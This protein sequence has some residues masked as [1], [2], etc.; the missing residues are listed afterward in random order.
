MAL[1]EA[2]PSPACH[3]LKLLIRTAAQVDAPVE[4]MALPAAWASK[5]VACG[6]TL[7][8]HHRVPTTAI[9]LLAAASERMRVIEASGP[10]AASGVVKPW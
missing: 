8:G 5:T 3:L 2:D 9:T 4:I 1:E 6:P 10:S 7:T